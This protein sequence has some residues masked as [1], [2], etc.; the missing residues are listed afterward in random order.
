VTRTETLV[1]ENVNWIP[2][3]ERPWLSVSE[4]GTA[5]FA[6]GD[7]DKRQLVWIDRAG[8]VTEVS[9]DFDQLMSASVSRDGNKIAYTSQSGGWVRDLATNTK[10]RIL[11]ERRNFVGGWL[12]ND[13][14]VII[15]SNKTGN[16]DV[17]SVPAG[18]GDPKVVLS[19]PQAQ[20][21]LAV[22]TGRHDCVSRLR[23]RDRCRY[24]RARAGRQE[25]AARCDEVFRD[26]AG[27]LA[28]RQVRGVR[29]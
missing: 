16:W 11:D 28:G 18:G 15:S 29:V 26:L 17:Y 4:N 7:P 21:P 8:V 12:G 27:H 5:V 19:K 22:G 10:T 9:P 2:G 14:R 6:P 20:H 13:E 23:A 1:L 24:R 3:A 25:P